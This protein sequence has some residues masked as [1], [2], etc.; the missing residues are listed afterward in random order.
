MCQCAEH[1]QYQLPNEI[2]RVKYLLEGIDNSDPTLQAALALV[3]ADDGPN[4][5]MHDFES[6][7]AFLL[8]SDPVST[9]RGKKRGAHVSFVTADVALSS[10]KQSKGLMTGVEFRYYELSEWCMFNW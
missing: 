3:R 7:T 5:K 8:P 4:G 6:A 1:V 2:T 10:G 9:R